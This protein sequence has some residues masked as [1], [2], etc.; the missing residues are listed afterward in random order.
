[1][2]PTAVEELKRGDEVPVR[3]WI[4]LNLFKFL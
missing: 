4:R 3:E 2:V 1:M